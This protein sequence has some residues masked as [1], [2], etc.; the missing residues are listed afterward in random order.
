[1]SKKKNETKA[2]P[3]KAAVKSSSSGKGDKLRRGITQDEWGE[4][5]EKVFRSKEKLE[6]TESRS[7]YSSKV[8]GRKSNKE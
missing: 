2:V 6:R 4:K 8:E 3:K 7:I 1:M 5:W